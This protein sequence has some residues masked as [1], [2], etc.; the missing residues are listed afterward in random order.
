MPLLSLRVSVICYT[1]H[2]SV[3]VAASSRFAL[4]VF[5]PMYST[6]ECPALCICL[7]SVCPSVSLPTPL[8]SSSVCAPETLV[9]FSLRHSLSF[10]VSHCLSVSLCQSLSANLFPSASPMPPPSLSLCQTLFVSPSRQSL[11]LPQSLSLLCLLESVIRVCLA[12]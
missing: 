8:L 1:P 9:I 10:C 5:L 12:V 6:A 4:L 3:C 11:S 2:F 7:S